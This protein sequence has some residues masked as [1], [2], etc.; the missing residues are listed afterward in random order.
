MEI[1]SDSSV[2]IRPIIPSPNSKFAAAQPNKKLHPALAGI[3]E[4]LQQG[5]ALEPAQTALVHNG[6]V[7]V[8]VWLND[9]S[10]AVLEQ[11]RRL[12]FE[13]DPP[14]KVAKIR[15]GQIATGKLA[16]LSRLPVVQWVAPRS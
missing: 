1:Q 15:T 11:L 2:A 12:G 4:S 9:W 5:R 16:E 3:V 14:G 6:K 7:R 10:P 8:E 13:A